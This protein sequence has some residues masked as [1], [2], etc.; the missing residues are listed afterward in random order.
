[1]RIE[2]DSLGEREVPEAAY[3][4]IHSLRSMENFD[5]AGERLPLEIIRG[6]VQLK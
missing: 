5:V 6:I 2:R 3:F 4:G 1:M